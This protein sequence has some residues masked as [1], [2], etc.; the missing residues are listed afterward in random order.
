[1]RFLM[2]YCDP[3]GNP[4]NDQELRVNDPS[5]PEAPGKRPWHPP[6]LEETDYT[7]TELGGVGIYYDGF[8]YSNTAP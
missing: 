1:M 3:K 5:T 4:M 2:V 6:T 8:G 7:A